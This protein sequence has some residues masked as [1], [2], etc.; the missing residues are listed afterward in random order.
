[1]ATSWKENV[2]TDLGLNF[3]HLRQSIC[4]CSHVHFQESWNKTLIFQIQN[5]S[6]AVKLFHL[7]SSKVHFAQN[8]QH[9]FTHL[10]PKSSQRNLQCKFPNFIIIKLVE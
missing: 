4:C 1:M 10:I 8:V 2:A 6:N 3:S 7:S 5:V 9:V